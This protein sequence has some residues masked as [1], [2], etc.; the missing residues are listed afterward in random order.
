[1]LGY[2]SAKL[3]LVLWVIAAGNVGFDVA[4]GDSIVRLA[5]RL[6]AEQLRSGPLAGAWLG[7]E[8][9]T[10]SI[11]T[12]LVRAYTLTCDNRYRQAAGM[13]EQFFIEAAEGNLYGD[14]AYALTLLDEILGPVPGGRSA[15]AATFYA[16]VRR[17]TPGGT[18]GYI[19][20]YSQAELS[21]AVFY[22][23]YHTVAAHRV[24]DKDKNLWRQGLIASLSQVSDATAVF[25]VM[26]LGVA[27]WALAQTGSLDHSL[28]D[29]SGKGALCW[30]QMRFCDLP[31]VLLSHQVGAEGPISGSFYWRF[32]HGDQGTGEAVSGYTEDLVFACLGLVMAARA[33][34]D[35]DVE[36]GI[37]SAYRAL[38]ASLA[39]KDLVSEHL[40][41]ASDS[42]ALYAGEVLQV[43]KALSLPADLDLTGKVDL[44]DF[45]RW[46]G[47]WQQS[48]GGS[49]CDC[50]FAR[51]D[52]D[53]DGRVDWRDMACIAGGWMSDSARDRGRAG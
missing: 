10:G 29:P 19:L 49:F 15:A 13:G 8:A 33:C 51:S 27:T 24:E 45:S 23:A 39:G 34:P 17:K 25:P 52:L 43:L 31:D 50:N 32:D 21:A 28:I 42:S 26:S 53:C 20:Q 14:E 4:P 16:N 44:R 47:N 36:A 6:T 2:G 5:D 12:G 9:Y 1:M 48:D 46:A 30:R 38:L 11:V 37:N 35:A 3:G 40:T 7:E 41:L 18:R 22:L